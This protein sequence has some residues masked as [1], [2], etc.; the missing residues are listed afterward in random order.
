MRP[1]SLDEFVGQRD[2]LAQGGVLRSLVEGDRLRSI[3]LWG[4]AGTGKTTLARLLAGRTRAEFLQL[5]AVTA[6]VADVRRAVEEG[7]ARLRATGRRTVL[8]IDEVHRFS[9]TQQDALLPGVEDGSVVFAGATTENPYSSVTSPLLSRSL[10]FRLERLSDE[11]VGSILDRAIADARGLAGRARVGAGAR[12]ELASRAE[13]D[14]RVALNALEA[15]ADRAAARGSAEV[16]EADAA[17]A[18]RSRFARYDRAGD[19]HYDAASAFIKSMRGSDPDAAVAWLARMIHGGEDPRFI[20]RR[21]LIFASEDIGMADPSALSVAAA[22]SRAVEEVGLPEAR[23]SL[24]HAAIYLALAPKSN[25]VIR[26]IDRAAEDVERRG[27]GE[28]PVHLR[29]GAGPGAGALGHGAGYKY[30]HDY[31]GGVVEQEHGPEGVER[32]RYWWPEEDL[33]ER[34]A[35]GSAARPA[36]AG[37]HD[38][39]GT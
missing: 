23:I 9:R 3:V 18:L 2:I 39:N 4:P 21:M 14:A 33:A 26:A 1:R 36:G 7:R 12:A 28:V 20:A 8:F 24:A 37:D 5:S 30:P 19:R 31:P 17:D 29:S 6:G 15:A 13:G 32:R 22:T 34:R 11:E 10:L 38:E 27:G 35:R 16:T 25:A